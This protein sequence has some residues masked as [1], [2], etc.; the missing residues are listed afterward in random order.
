MYKKS[1]IVVVILFLFLRVSAQVQGI[2]KFSVEWLNRKEL[3]EILHKDTCNL[4]FDVNRSGFLLS[5]INELTH[6]NKNEEQNKVKGLQLADA[7]FEELTVK[8]KSKGYDDFHTQELPYNIYLNKEY[9][10]LFQ[11]VEFK[12][13]NDTCLNN[14]LVEEDLGLIKWEILDVKKDIQGFNCQKAT[15]WFRG[16]YYTAWY[17]PDIPVSFGPWKL[18]GL[19]GLILFANDRDNKVIF[20]LISIQTGENLFDQK[21]IAIPQNINLIKLQ[22]IIPQI[23]KNI[24]IQSDEQFN[25]LVSRLPRSM[26]ITSDQFFPFQFHIEKEYE[27]LK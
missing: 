20:K 12:Q 16:R 7:N 18:N 21:K 9:N 24:K 4:Y 22:E 1:L 26:Y 27:F 15:A 3:G 19:P 13:I 11:Y 25:W 8:L 10:R 6:L 2:A 17:T 14:Y 5:P 23:A